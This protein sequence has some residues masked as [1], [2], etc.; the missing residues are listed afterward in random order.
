MNKY[1]RGYEG[2]LYLVIEKG[3]HNEKKITGDDVILPCYAP[4]AF[5]VTW[6]KDGQP[7][8]FDLQQ[9]FTVRKYLHFY[10]HFI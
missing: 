9:R 1:C 2:L 10:L 5:S 8:E 3:P 7:I 6:K 4:T